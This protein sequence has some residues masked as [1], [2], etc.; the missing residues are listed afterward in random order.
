MNILFEYFIV[1]TTAKKIILIFLTI[2]VFFRLCSNCDKRFFVFR[3]D[4]APFVFGSLFILLMFFV[5]DYISPI[6]LPLSFLLSSAYA[7]VTFA[8]HY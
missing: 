6:P 3:I 7:F 1:T 5:S 4:S 2:C 8:L